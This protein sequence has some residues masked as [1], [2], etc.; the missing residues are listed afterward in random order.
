MTKRKSYWKKTNPLTTVLTKGERLIS[1]LQNKVGGFRDPEYNRVAFELLQYYATT[2]TLTHD[3]WEILRTLNQKPS[4]KAIGRNVF[5]YA[6]SAGNEVKIGVSSKPESRKRD[7]QVGNANEIEI[8]WSIGPVPRKEALG[9]EKKLH[10]KCKRFSIRGE[11][12][13][14]ECMGTVRSFS[15]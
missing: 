12:F 5:L 8:L 1:V 11:W 14:S 13:K 4:R 6:M 10:R 7:M 15:L 2:G 9:L 3:Q